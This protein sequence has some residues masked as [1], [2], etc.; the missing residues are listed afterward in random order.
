MKNDHNMQFCFCFF[1]FFHLWQST[2]N[3]LFLIKVLTRW[4][5]TVIAH[6]GQ[7]PIII[8]WELKIGLIL[9]LFQI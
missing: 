6:F 3:D 9:Q 4:G 2:K 8:L 5:Y 7:M 1:L